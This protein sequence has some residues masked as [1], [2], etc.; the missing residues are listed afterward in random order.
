MQTH[1]QPVCSVSARPHAGTP[2]CWTRGASAGDFGAGEAAV[3]AVRGVDLRSG[4]GRDRPR[5]GPIRAAA[6]RRCSRCSAACCARA[7]ARSGID[8]VRDHRRLPSASCPRFRARPVRLHLP[9]LQPAAALSA[10]ENVEVRPQPRRRRAAR[11][12]HERAIG[13]LERA[14]SRATGSLPAGEALGRREAAGRDRPRGRQRAGADPR[15]RADGQPRLAHGARRCAS[16]ATSPSEQWTTR[17][18]RQPRRAPAGDRRPGPLARG[19]GVQTRHLAGSRPGLRN[20][21]R[22]GRRSRPGR[23]RWQVTY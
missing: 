12:A 7:R 13:L 10:Q 23:A 4:R 6:R 16:F 18:D 11:G 21:H 9:G 1:A 2:P 15:R 20:G 19:R 22:A 5:H 3:E 14:G 8:G 17:P